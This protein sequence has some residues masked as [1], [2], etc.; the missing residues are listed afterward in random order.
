MS[1]GLWDLRWGVKGRRGSAVNSTCMKVGKV[2]RQQLE[3]EVKGNW[4]VREQPMLL[5]SHYEC[6]VYN[7]V[8]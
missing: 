1:E 4:K 5:P 2:R 6:V 3:A 7:I 8:T